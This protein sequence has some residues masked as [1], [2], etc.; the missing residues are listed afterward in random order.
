MECNYLKE[1]PTVQEVWDEALPALRLGD[2]VVDCMKEEE[3]YHFTDPGVHRSDVDEDERVTVV[4][5]PPVMEVEDENKE[6]V[7]H[8]VQDEPT[9]AELNHC[10]T[11]PDEYYDELRVLFG[12]WWP[13][14]DPK[15]LDHMISVCMAFDTATAFAMSFGMAKFELAQVEAKLVG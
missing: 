15:L 8:L 1:L 11:P 7:L 12:K 6:F 4:T 5:E 13:K 3:L 10:V 14:A 9:I 2:E